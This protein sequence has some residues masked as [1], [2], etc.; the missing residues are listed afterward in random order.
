MSN[1]I[2]LELELELEFEFHIERG[3]TSLIGNKFRN[4][5]LQLS[6]SLNVLFE[7]SAHKSI[8][9][10]LQRF[11]FVQWFS[12][13]LHLDYYFKPSFMLTLFSSSFNSWQKPWPNVYCAIWHFEKS[14]KLKYLFD[15]VALLSE[16]YLA[17]VV[18]LD[19]LKAHTNH[20]NL[21]AIVSICY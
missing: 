17:F 10:V 4:K 19:R 7:C 12:G 5:C 20:M 18:S 21:M 1:C 2:V 9:F 11:T 13:W 3:S 6:T 14:S 8:E 15:A 16:L